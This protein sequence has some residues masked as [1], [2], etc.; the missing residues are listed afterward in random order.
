MASVVNEA[1]YE[2]M[3]EALTNF[4]NS[5]IKKASDMQVLADTGK[6]ALGDNDEGAAELCKKVA[7]CQVKYGDAAKEARDIAQAMQ[8]ELDRQRKERAVWAS[9]D[10]E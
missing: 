9:E 10:G 3:I 1:Q 7:D 2:K 6:Q 4:A 5:V 8:E